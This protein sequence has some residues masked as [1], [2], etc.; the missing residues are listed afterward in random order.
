[1]YGETVRGGGGT[2]STP[3]MGR[4]TPQAWGDKDGVVRRGSGARDGGAL[5]GVPTS[6]PAMSMDEL[7]EDSRRRVE[8]L[9]SARGSGGT[10]ESAA[11]AARPSMKEHQSPAAAGPEK[12]HP[13]RDTLALTPQRVHSP[14]QQQQ[15]QQ[16]RRQHPMPFDSTAGGDI[17]AILQRMAADQLAET[18]R[19]IHAEVRNV[20]VEL[21]KQFHEMREE[22]LAMFEEIRGAQRELALEVEALR[23]TQ[24]EYVRR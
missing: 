24:Q 16:A 9:L 3:A 10:P 22:Q 7:K 13:P 1:M 19:V 8:R 20:H 15:Q 11:A 14:Q 6:S 17:A 5:D 18:K 23:R 21:L 2:P 12:N 4:V